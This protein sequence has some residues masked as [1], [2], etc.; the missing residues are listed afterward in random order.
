MLDFSE[1][2]HSQHSYVMINKF[3]LLHIHM[4]IWLEEVMLMYTKLYRT[5]QIYG[6]GIIFTLDIVNLRNLLLPQ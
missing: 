5:K 3:T 2:E 6:H 1:I 4:S